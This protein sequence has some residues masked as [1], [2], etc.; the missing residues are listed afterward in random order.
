MGTDSLSSSPSLSVLEQ[1]KVI[2]R[3]YPLVPV[4]ELMRWATRNGAEALGFS[5]L[6]RIEVG[7]APGLNAIE[8][9]GV[10]QG[11]LSAARVVPLAG[12][13]GLR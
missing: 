6:G 7:L 3:Y 12:L 1:L 4:P 11:D 2:N 8:G 9:D 5:H 10:L 13:R